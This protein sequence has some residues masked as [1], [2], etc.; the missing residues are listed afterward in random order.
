MSQAAELA[1]AAEQIGRWFDARAWWTL[2]ARSDRSVGQ[3]AEAALERI[4]RIEAMFELGDKSLAAVIEPA[5]GVE[6]MVVAGS[7]ALS[8]PAFYDEASAGA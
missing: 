8:V 7:H 1:R 5:G 3:E 6:R 4:P 2:A